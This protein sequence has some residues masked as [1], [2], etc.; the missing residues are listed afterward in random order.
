[1]SMPTLAV[2]LNWRNQINKSGLYPVHIR[3]GI[4]DIYRYY[5]MAIPKKVQPTEWAGVMMPG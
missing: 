5:K 3:I 4:N 2:V 1:M